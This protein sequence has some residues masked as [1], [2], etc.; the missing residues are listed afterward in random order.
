MGSSTSIKFITTQSRTKLTAGKTC[1]QGQLQH[2]NVLGE[3]ET[4]SLFADYCGE[5]ESRTTRYVD[6]LT[7]FIAQQVAAGYRI[8]FGGFAVGLKLRG[9]FKS[10]N[11][12]F[13]PQTNAVSVEMIPGKDI[14]KAAQ[15]LKPLNVTDSTK[16]RLTGVLQQTPFEV[17]DQIVP[18]GERTL[19]STGYMPAVDPSKPDEGIWVEDDDGTRVLTG[20]VVKSNFGST[21]Y[22]LVGPIDRGE[23]WSVLQGRYRDEPALIR[24]R[25]RL[26]VA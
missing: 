12:A 18:D 10:M 21:D 26:T 2:N 6:A 1:Y 4:K 23:Y 17:W 7:E 25:H 5:P 24:V 3:K 8:D 20:E 19:T 22:R 13:D 9:G 11:A 14:R 16:W 15:T